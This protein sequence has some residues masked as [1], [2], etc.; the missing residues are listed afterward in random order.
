MSS[1]KQRSGLLA[2]SLFKNM[3]PVVQISVLFVSAFQFQ[4]YGQGKTVICVSRLDNTEFYVNV[5]LIET[6][7][8]R[9]DTVISLTNG[10]KFVV[11][12]AAQEIV[13]RVIAFRNATHCAKLSG[14]GVQTV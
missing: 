3:M 8:M 11:R 2:T 5:D 12:E 10:K 9:P 4:A 6:I 13:S 1:P 14:S 7:E